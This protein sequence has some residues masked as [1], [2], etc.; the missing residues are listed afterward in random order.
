LSAPSRLVGRKAAV[1]KLVSMVEAV[2]QPETG[3]SRCLLITGAPGVGKSVLV[4]QLRSIVAERAGWFVAGK[5]DQFRRGLEANG[6]W[7]A[8]S[9][10]C[11]LLLAEPEEELAR[12]RT[13]LLGEIGPNIGLTCSFFPELAPLLGF[14]PVP[15]VSDPLAARVR[16]QQG[17]L[18]L[19]AAVASPQ[20]PVVMVLDD[21][22]WAPES[23]LD[24]IDAVLT[25]PNLAGV[26]V[27]GAYRESEIAP[28]HPLTALLERWRQLGVPPER[29]RLANLPAPEIA[30]MVSE[31]LRLPEDRTA[32]LANQIAARTA[33]NPY[34]IVEL[35]DAL[36]RDD[37]LV[38][39]VDGWLWDSKRIRSLPWRGDVLTL[40]GARLAA[41]PAPTVALLEIMACLGGEVDAAML[42]DATGQAVAEVERDLVAAMEDGLIVASSRAELVR[43][44]HDRMREATF[45][46]IS[47]E[48]LIQ[49]RL[50]LGRRLAALPH[51]QVLAAEQYLPVAEAVHSPDERR[52]LVAVF[53]TAAMDAR[54]SSNYA[55]SERFLTAAATLLATTEAA[56][57]ALVEVAIERHS[58]LFSLGKLAE[59]DQL[60]E[61]ITDLDRDPMLIATATTTQI[62]SLTS[63]NRPDDAVALG[64]TFLASLGCPAPGTPADLV[65]ETEREMAAMY[66]W[67]AS[68]DERDDLRRRLP[69][70]AAPHH[71]HDHQPDGGRRVQVRVPGYPVAAVDRRADVGRPW[72]SPRVRRP[73]ELPPAGDPRAARRLPHRRGDRATDPGGK[74]GQGVRTG[75]LAGAFRIRVCLLPVVRTP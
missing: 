68:G 25:D 21:L 9:G 34:D 36:R 20:R 53:R 60:Y 10:L 56:T 39:T 27:V 62:S 69:G 19:L 71:R 31:M 40:L 63:Q 23:P 43:F 24:F 35:V 73:A 38:P 2:R 59:A 47:A 12:L 29:L 55:R 42:A 37:A 3:R 74:R 66:A 65:A 75:D 61:Q 17:G 8:M 72:P 5:F 52:E 33:G 26:L 14:P 54:R 46:R 28:D 15:R 7:Q 16:I 50:A 18:G 49:L 1:E 4:D 30:T 11:R 58:V 64:L 44:R 67:A 45:G 6:A 57:P 51:R 70:S 22:Q 41:L 13:R 48:R 32:P